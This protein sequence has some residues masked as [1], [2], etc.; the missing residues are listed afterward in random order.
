MIWSISGYKQFNKCPRQWYYSNIVADARVKNDLFRKDVT[1][2]SKLQSIEAWR[3]SIVDD[4]I[5]RLLVN[6]LNRKLPINGDY[7]KNEAMLSFDQQLNYAIFQQYRLPESK[8]SSDENFAALFAYEFGIEPTIE[9]IEQARQDIISALDNLLADE[10]FLS[11]LRSAKLLVSQ[12]TLLY[13]FDRFNVRAI[14]DL[15]AFFDDKPPHIF[16]WKVHTYGTIT[17][18]EQLI[19]YAV[20]LYKVLQNKPHKDFPK[21]AAGFSIYDYKLTEYQLLHKEHI[22]RDYEVTSESLEEF[23]DHINVSIIEMYRTGCHKKYNQL[24]VERFPT[25]NYVENCPKCAFK[26]ICQS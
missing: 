19:S 24:E 26:K 25:T 5:S 23:S 8:L 12:R 17:Y 2:L 16:D 1:I 4:V 3:G 7:L 14:P 11:Y 21:N 18:D 22:K 10:E 9:D 6:T 15:I 13:G 20:A